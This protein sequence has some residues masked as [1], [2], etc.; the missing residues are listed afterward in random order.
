MIKQAR[1]A[2]G[3]NKGA[4]RHPL[5]H[6]W[7]TS[8]PPQKIVWHVLLPPAHS[9]SVSHMLL[10]T[11]QA[12][13]SPPKKAFHPSPRHIKRRH[14]TT[15]QPYHSYVQPSHAMGP[16]VNSTCVQTLPLQ[17]CGMKSCLSLPS[18]SVCCFP[19]PT[20]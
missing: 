9:N 5:L 1:H 14:H 13:A 15:L 11:K 6:C 7:P 18:T 17:R 3:N 4:R 8:T 12:L 19:C 2:K 10:G 20:C 16:F